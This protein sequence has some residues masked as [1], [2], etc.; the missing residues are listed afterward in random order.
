MRAGLVE[1]PGDYRWSSAAAH[2]EGFDPTG[3]VDLKW[4]RREYDG[5]DC[6]QTLSGPDSEQI[7]PLRR[8][9]YAGRPF[10]DEQFV[11][12]ISERFGRHWTRGRPRKEGVTA[13]PAKVTSQLPLFVEQT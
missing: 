12:A 11:E 5:L 13:P 1:W 4:W 8:C 3:L 2:L 7:G 9:T 6:G 10:G